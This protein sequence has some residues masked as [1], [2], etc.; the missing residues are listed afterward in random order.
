MVIFINVDVGFG[1]FEREFIGMMKNKR[2]RRRLMR[3]FAPYIQ[4]AVGLINSLI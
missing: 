1:R 4:E 3:L 2:K